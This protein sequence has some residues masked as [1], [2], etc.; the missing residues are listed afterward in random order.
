MVELIEIGSYLFAL[1]A[2]GASSAYAYQH[3][4]KLDQMCSMMVGMIYSTLAGFAFGTLYAIFTGQYLLANVL[5]IVVGL[6]VG[7]FFSLKTGDEFARMEAVMG[8]VMGGLMGAMFGFMIRFEDRNL[9][10]LF[11]LAVIALL[12]FESFYFIK[13][14][15]KKL[16][17]SDC[18]IAP[19][20]QDQKN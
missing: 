14:Y 7:L 20:L 4:A 6:A 18:C 3:K 15:N 12:S 5:G 19:Q 9:T 11:I 10:I 1:I 8:A 13:K 17:P 16:T 2:V